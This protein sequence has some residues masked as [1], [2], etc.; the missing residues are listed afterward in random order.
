MFPLTATLHF[1][2]WMTHRRKMAKRKTGTADPIETAILGAI[3]GGIIGTFVCLAFGTIWFWG[4]MAVAGMVVGAILGYYF[5]E[6]ILELLSEIA[7]N[8]PIDTFR[9]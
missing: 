5:D 8:W 4:D 6:P 7:R 3:L 1:T 9:K 2:H